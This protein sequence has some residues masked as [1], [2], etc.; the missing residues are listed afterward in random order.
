MVASREPIAPPENL[1]A[2]VQV[3]SDRYCWLGRSAVRHGRRRLL[4]ATQPQLNIMPHHELASVCLCIA[5]ASLSRLRSCVASREYA[6]RLRDL[7][8]S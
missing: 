2:A 6:P 5:I 8:A 4:R 7:D 1:P 3:P